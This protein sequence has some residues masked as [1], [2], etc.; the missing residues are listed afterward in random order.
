MNQKQQSFAAQVKK[1]R[2][3]LGY[4]QKRMAKELGV[5]FA[6]VNRW[7]NKHT[8]PSQL[9]LRQFER[10]C[11]DYKRGRKRTPKQLTNALRGT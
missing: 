6:T 3:K 7:E 10:L 4:S 9:A 2:Q 5:S 8:E 11:E 1:A